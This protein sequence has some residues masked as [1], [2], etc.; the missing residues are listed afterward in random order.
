[1]VVRVLLL[2]VSSPQR[3][4]VFFFSLFSF[5]F[6]VYIIDIF[7]HHVCAEAGYIWYLRDIK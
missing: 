7:V 4:V 5:F 2:P 3:V 6:D 1:V